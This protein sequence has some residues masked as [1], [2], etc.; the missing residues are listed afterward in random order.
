MASK[1][2]QNPRHDPLLHD[3][4]LPLRAIY[5]PLGFSVEIVTNCREV[6]LAAQESWGHFQKA[7]DGPLL[8]ICIGVLDVGSASCAGLPVVRARRGLMARV[9]DAN[10]FSM[11]DIKRGFAFAW[12]T[13]ATVADNAYLRWHFIEGIAWDLLDPYVTAVHAACVRKDDCGILLCGDSGAGK[14][15]LSYVCALN[16]WTYLT[17]D[18]CCLIHRE[19]DRTVIGNPYQIRFRPSA[20]DLFP[21]LKDHRSKLRVNGERIGE[22]AFELPT[23]QLSRITI[24]MKS[25]VDYVIFLNRNHNGPACLVPYSKVAALR[26]FEQ[27]VCCCEKKVVGAHRAAL[28]QLVEAPILELRY[29]DLGSAMK[30]LETLAS[31]YRPSIP[32]TCASRR[33]LD[34]V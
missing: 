20:V 3:F 13:Q 22:M 2:K 19:H 4:E 25:F 28:R 9:A 7:F 32:R 6:L 5:H 14:S 21:E 33:D 15:S 8:R 16:G 31:G 30:E 12:L 17:D 23:A 24:T 29:T 10:N 11:S 18:S 34:N 26:W 1:S 27:I